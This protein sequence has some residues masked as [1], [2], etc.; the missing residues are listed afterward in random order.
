MKPLPMLATAAAPFD[1]DDY[2]FEVKWDGVRALA[3][4]S[5]GQWQLWGRQGVDYTSRY[6][7]LAVLRRL[8]AGT[9]V[10]GELVVMQRGRADLPALLRRHQRRTPLRPDYQ[11]LPLTYVLFDLLCYRGASMFNETLVRRRELLRALLDRVDDPMLAYS[12]AVVGCG[13]AF[14]EQVVAQ[15][16][17]GVM[18]KFQASRYCPGKRSPAWRKLKP[19]CL[20][21]CVIVGYQ[22]DRSGLQRLLVA[23]LR[24]GELQYAGHLERGLSDAARAELTLRLASKRCAQPVV[25]CPRLACWVEPDLYCQ[26]AFQGW[27][28]RGH[29]RHAIFRGLL[30]ETLPHATMDSPSLGIP[31]DVGRPPQ[32]ALP[33]K[34]PEFSPDCLEL[35][36]RGEVTVLTKAGSAAGAL[37]ARHNRFPRRSIMATKKK[38]SQTPSAKASKPR[39]AAKRTAKVGVAVGETAA[40]T[41][42]GKVQEETKPAV[43]AASTTKPLSAV[44]AAARVLAESGQA[45]SCPE[46]IAAMAAKGYWSSPA[47]KTPAST[48]YAA[49]LREINTKKDASRFRKTDRGKFTL[50]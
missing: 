45:M 22:S 2:V 49:L 3:G 15:G 50:A 43:A 46:L 11:G 37:P 40:T 48:L 7:E 34:I 35:S 28:P 26:V 39:A 25:P 14:F 18:A 41:E 30:D 36:P 47:G 19:A 12:D 24:A 17:E 13:R 42:T 6:P 23:T 31:T 38:A 8:P 21:P 32:P 20:S 27:T 33:D 44:A 1:S 5:T 9:V 10:D 29:L 16:H 4:V